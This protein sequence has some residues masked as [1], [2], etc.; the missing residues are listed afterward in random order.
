MP[1]FIQKFARTKIVC[2]VGPTSSDV[3][4]LTQMVKAGADV[5]R[6]N[7]A[8]ASIEDLSVWAS[9]M[10]KVRKATGYP[11]G[12]MVDLPGIKIRA[13]RFEEGGPIALVEGERIALFP[14]TQ[15]GTADRIPVHPWPDPKGLRK[16]GIVLLDD[17]RLRAR[18][19]RRRG[20]TVEAE[21][22]Q[23]GL[24]EE[25]KGI[26]F[27]GVSLDLQVPTR[28]DMVLARAAIEAGADWLCQSFVAGPED[29][30]RLRA[31]TKRAGAP[32]IPIC[33]KIE[34]SECFEHLEEI[35]VA[36]N[37][38]MVA[39]GDL[40]VDA[41]AENVPHLQKEIIETALR[42][43]RPVVV[44][45]EMLDSM[46]VRDRPTR[47]EVSD[48]AN[49][50]FEGADGVML[51]GETAVGAHPVLAVETM[52]RILMTSE[53]APHALYAGSDQ[54]EGPMLKPDRPD[55]HVVHA[56]VT[57]AERTAARAI[58]VFSRSGASVLRTSKERP[59]A[60]IHGFTPTD[61]ISRQLTLAWG[62]KPQRLP[63][64]RSFDAFAE[65]VI[66]LLLAGNHLN[67]GDRAVLVMG[68][69][70]DPI[71]ATTLI[72]LLTA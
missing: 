48:V 22:E 72:K 40:G 7:G 41:G 16:D 2:T 62:V 13:G 68:G 23:G 14:G 57:L 8:H 6:V 27:R 66:D 53:K 70:K 32:K 36:S 4:T 35:L 29:V 59:R 67:R 39:R 25:R 1:P 5:I 9:R 20:D 61:D 52:N 69:A 37:A 33:T 34:R 10:R 43:G 30:R 17:G 50:V 26:A 18:I 19:L 3:P 63:R 28:R 46:T 11:A 21:V 15:G 45:T 55:Q 44:A 38:C 65:K 42:V 51:S 71:G 24:L 64:G 31:L 54:L 60:L 56:A 12:L 47:A 58:V 49:A